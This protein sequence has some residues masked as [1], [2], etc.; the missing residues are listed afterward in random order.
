MQPDG[1][2]VRGDGRE[3]GDL[4]EQPAETG[5]QRQCRNGTRNRCHLQA[6]DGE[7]VVEPGRAKPREQRIAHPLRPTEDDRPE[8]RAPVSVQTDGRVGGE[9]ALQ[10]VADGSEAPAAADDPPVLRA[11]HDVDALAAKP[12]ALVE[13]VRRP[14]RETEDADERQA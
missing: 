11:Q 7:H 4:R 1:E 8:H 10:P 3:R 13:A 12:G 6:V 9:P 14:A 2:R 5:E